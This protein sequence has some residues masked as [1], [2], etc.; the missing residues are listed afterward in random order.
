MIVNPIPQ[1]AIL[2]PCYNEEVAIRSVIADFRAAL[3]HAVIH[4]FDNNS[5]D[6]TARYAQEAGAYVHHVALSGKGNVVRRMFADVEADAYVLVDGDATYHAPSA[7]N[8]V[9][10]LLNEQ[11]DMVVGRR[12]SDEPSAYRAGHRFGNRMLTGFVSLL[13][14]RAFNDILSGYRV[15]SR[16]FTKSFP[17][18]SHGFEIETELT[19]HALELRMPIAEIDTPYAARPQGSFSKLSTYRDGLRILGTIAKLFR[20]ERPMAFFSMLGA[21]LALVA[22]LLALPL[23]LTYLQTGLVPRI[24]TAILTTGMMG[25]ALLSFVCGLI[26]DTV[27]QGRR[28]MK[29]L[30]YLAIPAW[31]GGT[32][33]S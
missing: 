6:Q 28:E 16:R 22:L 18:L 7:V 21:L 5:S 8:M 27:T 13:F 29:R 4:V 25:A 33:S 14:G 10:A 9:E 3:P 32:R 2:I 15:F 12:I 1:V 23:G 20:Q 11:L 31:T 19:V 24:P 30:A 26:L 17:A